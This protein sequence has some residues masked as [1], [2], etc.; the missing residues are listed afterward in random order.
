MGELPRE[1]PHE[2]SLEIPRRILAK[3]LPRWLATPFATRSLPHGILRETARET[4]RAPPLLV[5]RHP[6]L[7]PQVEDGA[8][9]VRWLR[10]Q[11]FCNGKVGAFGVSYLGLAAWAAAGGCEDDSMLDAV[12]PVMASARL[13]PVFIDNGGAVAFD[14]GLRWLYIVLNLQA[15]RRAR[16]EARA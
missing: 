12:A 9:A 11:P 1:M 8:E 6:R 4:A 7:S 14:L 2:T 16:T 13:F 10:A 5:S 3:S 15:C